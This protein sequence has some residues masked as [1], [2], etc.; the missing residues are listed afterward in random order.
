M[1]FRR[2]FLF[3]A[4]AALLGFM[5]LPAKAAEEYEIRDIVF[6]TERTV[7]Y[8][9]NFGDARS[10]HSHEGI[11]MMGAHMTPLYA[12]VDGRVTMVVI[13]EASWG[14]AVVIEDADDYTYHYLHINNDTPG[15]DDGMGGVEYAYAPG[16]KR[17]AKVT[18]GQLIGWMGD[19]GN[20]ENAGNHL[21]FEIRRPGG[22]AIDPYQSLLRAEGASVE[23]SVNFDVEIAFD[24][25]PTI[26]ADKNLQPQT[27][28]A[29]CTSGSLVKSASTTAVYYCGANGK[30]FVFPN[31]R[32]YF[33]WYD[34]F[35]DVVTITNEELAAIPLGGNVTY[36]P[37]SVMVKIESMPNVYA[38][39]VN[40]TLRWVKSPSVA[41]MLYGEDWAKQVQDLSD[42]FFNS[43]SFGEEIDFVN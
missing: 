17:G 16:I 3:I 22:T 36:R 23:G 4:I 28:T 11:D 12:A 37:G 10:G 26:N 24:K 13:P 14:Y 39:D 27:G 6:P 5:A 15:T 18:K 42:A 33:S 20:A 43:Y 1:P 32:V 7:T 30:R 25:S 38:V 21:H 34:D 35:D 19:S 8:T 2:S 41:A 40:G 31:D 9:D 29:P